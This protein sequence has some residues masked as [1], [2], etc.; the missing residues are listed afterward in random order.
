MGVILITHD[1]GLAA[2]HLRHDPRHVRGPD[3]RAQPRRAALR[4]PGASRTARRCS[5]RSAASTRTSTARSPRSADSRPSRRQLP[6][7]CP[8]HPRC[9]Y[10]FDLLPDGAAAARREL[11]DDRRGHRCHL[12]EHAGGGWRGRERPA[13]RRR[14]GLTGISGSEAA[15]DRQVV[16]AVDGVS[17]EIG[18][19]ETFGLVGESGSGKSTLARL[20]LRLDRPTAGRVALRRA[21]HRRAV[22][23]RAPPAAA[24]DADRLPGPVLVAEPAPDGRAVGRSPPARPQRELRPATARERVS[25]AARARRP[26]PDARRRLPAR[27]LRRAVPASVDRARARAPAG[28]R[29]PRRGRLGGRRLDPGA[30]PQPPARAAG[31]ARADVPLRQPRPRGRALHVGSARGDVRR[32]I[33]ESGPARAAL[34][35]PASTRTRTRC[36]PRSRRMPRPTKRSSRPWSTR[37]RTELD[38]T[39]C[40]FHPRCPLGDRTRCR[41][42][43]PVLER[44]GPDHAAACHFPQT[45]QSLLAEATASAG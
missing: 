12:A 44:V 7:G 37:R 18:R 4:R 27:A 14:E 24:Q 9:P 11:T 10:A 6:T 13:A 16:R 31:A 33:V 41:E 34:R 3:R 5:A 45:E 20:L 26:S 22:A 17:F 38:V 28:A 35:E 29:R 21:R 43:D 1:L 15:R 42:I 8:F 30:D 19:G 40:R 23:A 32:K 39:G 2:T 25:R 36:S